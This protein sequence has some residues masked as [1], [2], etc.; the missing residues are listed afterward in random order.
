MVMGY[1]NATRLLSVL[2][3]AVL[4]G[5]ATM[6]GAGLGPP[7]ETVSPEPGPYEIGKQHLAAGRIG[8]AVERFE[9]AVRQEP[10][11]V[12]ALNALAASYDRLGRHDLSARYYLRAL[13]HDP[14]SLQTLNNVGYSFLLQKKF[15]LALA[16]LRD[17]QAQDSDD[18]VVAANLRAA[19]IAYWAVTPAR[20]ATAPE[21]GWGTPSPPAATPAA[22]TV[23]PWL[24]RR[25]AKVQTLTTRSRR[26]LAGMISDAGSSPRVAIHGIAFQPGD[27]R[28]PKPISAPLWTRD[29]GSAGRRTPP[30]KSD[31]A[32]LPAPISAPLEPNPVI[33]RDAPR[34]NRPDADR[35]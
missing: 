15:D 26:A 17:A 8:L 27:D 24:G 2:A 7:A 16:Y 21:Q 3:L 29:P 28:L 1:S 4:G 23:S 32:L 11:S 25:H 5:C 9:S 20:A 13:I 6:T 12:E 18:P 10:S 33:S 22:K 34:E 31:T 14:K 19:R 30:T 35:G